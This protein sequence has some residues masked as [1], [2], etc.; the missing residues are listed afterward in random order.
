MHVDGMQSPCHK[1]E[2]SP[3]IEMQTPVKR[4]K[5]IDE[6]Q[7]CCDGF[8][9]LFRLYSTFEVDSLPVR[10]LINIFIYK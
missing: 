8:G 4:S 6:S 2:G 9:S 7:V 3:N 1:R 10:I 5:S